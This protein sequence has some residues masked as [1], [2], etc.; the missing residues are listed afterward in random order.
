MAGRSDFPLGSYSVLRMSSNLVAELAKL[1]WELIHSS[2]PQNSNLEPPMFV[3]DKCK[4]DGICHS[5]SIHPAGKSFEI[6]S[7][8]EHRLSGPVET[9]EGNAVSLQ[10]A[11]E[12]A[13]S[14]CIEL[15]G[16]TG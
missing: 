5:V 7:C 6:W 16:I 3:F 10:S 1:G 11:L 9:P 2:R 12:V 14:V 15:D 4:E 13:K 8:I